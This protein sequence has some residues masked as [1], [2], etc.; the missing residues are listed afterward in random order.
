M[1]EAF[2]DRRACAVREISK[3]HEES[4]EFTLKEGLAGEMRGEY[5]L[6]VEGARERENPLNKLSAREHTKE[7]IR[8]G[9]SKQ[10]AVKKAARD[11]GVS[12]NEVYKVTLD[13]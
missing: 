3:I 8:Q 6:L 5:V 4:M 13:L 2:G 1:Y 10:E 12:K 11:R 7:Y 9:L